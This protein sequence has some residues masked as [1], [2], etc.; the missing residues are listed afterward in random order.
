M[1]FSMEIDSPLRLLLQAEAQILAAQATI[2]KVLDELDGHAQR[3]HRLTDTLDNQTLAAIARRMIIKRRLRD[4]LL[5]MPEFFGE[6]AWDMMLALFVAH[7][8]EKPVSA[9]AASC[10][11]TVSDHTGQ[12]YLKALEKKG[13]VER[14]FEE[15]DDRVVLVKLTQSA[16]AL[17]AQLITRHLKDPIDPV[18]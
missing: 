14:V 4:R 12:R 15:G 17:M 8:E 2:S 18:D 3:P 5:C 6:P 7:L 9:A 1:S 10:L 16:V 11:S 13:L